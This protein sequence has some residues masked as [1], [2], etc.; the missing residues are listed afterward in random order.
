MRGE[1][2][3]S[4]I[5]AW[6]WA[7]VQR[8][9]AIALMLT[10][11]TAVGL[12]SCN[13]PEITT[14]PL[15]ETTN[16]AKQT[17]PLGGRL[18]EVSPP[19]V[20]QALKPFL[21][22]YEPQVQ[23]LSPREGETLTDT[24]ITVR[25]RVRD[26]PIYKDP[27]LNLG[28]HFH[29][30]L[31]DQPGQDIYDA[32]ATIAFTDL[33]PGTHTLRAF[34]ARPWHESFK[35]EAAYDQVTFNVFTTSSKNDAGQNAPLLTYSQ[36]Q[37]IYGSEPILLDFYLRNVPLHLIA[38]EDDSMSD[39]RIRCTVNDESFVFD[40]WQPLYLKGFKP[41]QNW[42]KLELIDET[43]QLFPGPFN[44]AIG[45][46]E[47]RPG[48]GDPLSNLIRGEI[49]ID[50]A[51]VLVD[52]TYEPPAPETSSEPP[53]DN[54]GL[55]NSEP[56][57]QRQVD[58]G[59]RDEDNQPDSEMPQELVE[60]EPESLEAETTASQEEDSASPMPQAETLS[61]DDD[62]SPET[63]VPSTST[64]PAQSLKVDEQDKAD[65]QDSEE[66]AQSETVS[67]P[68][69]TVEPSTEQSPPEGDVSDLVDALPA[70][71][72]ELNRAGDS[73]AGIA[74][75][76]SPASID[77]QLDVEAVQDT[78]EVESLDEAAESAPAGEQNATANE[79]TAELDSPND[80][81]MLA[82]DAN[83]PG[84]STLVE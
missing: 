29:L 74:I 76:D 83:R 46:V 27:D 56:V 28:P 72:V 49:P 14:T 64:T 54:D 39:W 51:R 8:W 58:E 33:A 63:I 81:E 55:S 37:G 71:P 65:E 26:L 53:L 73:E 38:A 21:A 61:P 41:G 79:S 16:G 17:L 2:M 34:A 10:I 18:S 62:T 3:D 60:V 20:L 9:R 69:A 57:Q 4:G 31:D 84:L 66:A 45:L 82:P 43:G 44:S 15:I 24:S 48:E 23:I 52:P 40:R 5:F 35:N 75:P 47:Y 50:V 70:S 25:V 59:D 13:R 11:V 42:V 32:D 68:D 6:F 36:P 1:V 67:N 12:G 80:S 77:L 19:E 30:M 22:V 78:P 7:C